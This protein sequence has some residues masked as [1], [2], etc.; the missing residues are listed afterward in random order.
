MHSWA[1][2]SGT[3]LVLLTAAGAA[4]GVVIED[5]TTDAVGGRGVPSGWTGEPL[6]RRAE[7]DLI[8]EEH[9]GHRAPSSASTHEEPGGSTADGAA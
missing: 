2:V 5:W 8:I 7:Y 6:G 9:A 4:R 1:L 3:L